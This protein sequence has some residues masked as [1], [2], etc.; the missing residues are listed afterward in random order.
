VHVYDMLQYYI[1]TCRSTIKDDDL[2]TVVSCPKPKICTLR[3]DAESAAA[4]QRVADMVVAISR[5][6]VP[7]PASIS[8]P[9]A[10]SRP[11]L[12]SL[13]RA[14]CRCQ[15]NNNIYSHCKH[16]SSIVHFLDKFESCYFST[17]YL[18]L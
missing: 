13:Q 14:T 5:L 17:G 2:V 6:V 1:A 15:V 7:S 3:R 11:R 10:A 12:T 18:S 4:T 9:T 16:R 8:S